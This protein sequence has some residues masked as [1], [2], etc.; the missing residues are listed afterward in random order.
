M[1]KTLMAAS[2]LAGAVGA[3]AQGS[4]NW[5]D[6]QSGFAIS[7]ISPST[8]TPSLEQ[9]GNTSWDTP[10]GDATYSGGWIGGGAAPGGGIGATLASGPYGI[11]YQNANEF[12]MGL[13]VDTSL[14]ALTSDI[15]AGTPVATT[16][17][18][19]GSDA[20]LY[21]PVPGVYVSGLAP[22]T[23]VYVG[24]AAWYNGDGATSYA[25]SMA[26]SG[27][28]GFVE[29]SSEVSLGGGAAPPS[30]IDGLGLSSFSLAGTVPEPSTIAL[31]VIGASTFLMRLRRKQ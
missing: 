14:T 30:G 2:I 23:M 31:G 26:D 25:T 3:Y 17:L 15:L 1:K 28:E 12:T 16:T 22:A 21:N 18:L 29:S 27:V 5:G 7:I 10:A 13:Y 8:T 11:N 4:L 9:S 20:G 19:G 6:A 24:L